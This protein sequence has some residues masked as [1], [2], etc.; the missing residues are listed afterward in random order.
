MFRKHWNLPLPLGGEGGGLGLEN[1]PIRN[2]KSPD[3]SQEELGVLGDDSD[4]NKHILLP[5]SV[6]RSLSVSLSLSLS[7]SLGEGR[8][9]KLGGE[10]TTLL[11]LTPPYR[12]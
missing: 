7:L 12:L 9:E 3:Q 1:R 2:Q 4:P 10:R 5:L 6:F 8:W 11:H